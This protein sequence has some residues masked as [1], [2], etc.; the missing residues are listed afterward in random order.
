MKASIRQQIAPPRAAGAHSF[1]DAKVSDSG[2]AK[3]S[4]GS[5]ADDVDFDVLLFNSMQDKKKERRAKDAGDLTSENREEF[6]EKLADQTKQKRVPKNKLE[7]DD[8]LK[9]F[10]TQLQNQDPLNPDDGAELAA[11]LAQF[12]SVEQLMNVNKSL[13]SLAGAQSE[14]RSMQLAGI[15]GKEVTVDG[16]RLRIDRGALSDAEFTIQQPAANTTLEVRDSMGTVV[17][18]MP[19]GSLP[20][21][22]HNLSWDGSKADG[23]KVPDG[24]YTYEITA[25]NGKGME[26]PVSITSK[27]K[28]TGVDIMDKS[29]AVYTDFGK[30][31]M[32]EIKAVGEQGFKGRGP[33]AMKPSQPIEAGAPLAA[34][35]QKVKESSSK[36][37]A[38]K[39]K[40]EEP[41]AAPK[42][43]LELSQPTINSKVG[44]ES[45]AG[46]ARTAPTVEV[47][48]SHQVPPTA[49][50]SWESTRVES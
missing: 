18:S 35:A 43:D 29:G 30:I 7:K 47:P 4:T 11:K 10:V 42:S 36:N 28:I 2:K 13:E 44:Q 16:G 1:S 38:Q 17:R 32:D 40:S 19:L 6:L 25:R 45:P 23:A 37:E 39:E 31:R 14:D 15:I 48:A 41:S 33:T 24:A 8:F 3:D 22:S 20:A 34:I 46:I 12:N 49:P 27:V 50:K 26:M 5:P 21:G 9:L